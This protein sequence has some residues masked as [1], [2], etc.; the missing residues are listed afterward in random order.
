MKRTASPGLDSAEDPHLE[1]MRA[2][3][4]CHPGWDILRRITFSADVKADPPW[5]DWRTEVFLPVLR[6]QLERA[7][8]A[9]A[10]AD[11]RGLAV[12]DQ[13]LDAALP[14]VAATASRREGVAL[15][16]TYPAPTAERLWTKYGGLVATG[17]TPGHLAIV[18][19]VRAAAFHFPPA[20]V[21]A[22]Y[23]FLEAHG[24]LTARGLAAWMEMVEHCLPGDGPA[25]S[26]QIK[27][28]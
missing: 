23:I 24:G 13:A 10:T 22:A 4:L 3:R 21:V 17:E 7:C 6:P 19:A 2:I 25:V 8:L 1:L 16:R 18:L 15:M 11:W 12:S 27:V 9:A 20:A 26:P 14:S 5:R 28:A